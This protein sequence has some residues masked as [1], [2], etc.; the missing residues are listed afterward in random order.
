MSKTL[1]RDI[2]GLRAPGYP[3][4]IVEPPLPDPLTAAQYSCLYWVDHLLDCDR[5]HTTIDLKDGGSVY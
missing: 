5:G 1:Q 3:I 2:Y 4:E